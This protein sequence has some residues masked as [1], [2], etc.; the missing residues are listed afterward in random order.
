MSG[1]QRAKGGCSG[2][3]WH[4]VCNAHEGLDHGIKEACWGHQQIA[5]VVWVE[6]NS[7]AWLSISWVVSSCKHCCPNVQV[8]HKLCTVARLGLQVCAVA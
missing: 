1:Q 3:A 6:A 8:L 2:R 4:Q 5:R 7:A